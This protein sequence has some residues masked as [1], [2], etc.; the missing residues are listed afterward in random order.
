MF[1]YTCT[2]WRYTKVLTGDLFVY[3][4]DSGHLLVPSIP[5]QTVSTTIA[6]SLL[7]LLAQET[8]T[9]KAPSFWTGKL[10]VP[11]TLGR[12]G[13]GQWVLNF[14]YNKIYLQ[15]NHWRC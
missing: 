9:V 14:L 4:T 7:Q 2:Y 8:A 10:N 6:E 5:V 13:N 1:L 12:K 11:Y 15:D 3:L